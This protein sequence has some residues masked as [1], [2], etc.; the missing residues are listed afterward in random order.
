MN[1]K[2]ILITGSTDGIGKQTALELAKKGHHIIIHGRSMAKCQNAVDDILEEVP[3]AKL[4]SV[5]ADLASLQNIQAMAGTLKQRYE[6]L[7]VLINNAGVFAPKRRISQDGLEINFAVNYLASYFLTCEVLDLIRKSPAGRII[8]VS[9]VAH[10]RGRINFDDLF[11]ENNYQ[12]YK[13]YADSKLMLIYLTYD[14][15]EHLSDEG[16][17]VNALHPGVISTKLLAVGFNMSGDNLSA[18]AETPVYLAVSKEVKNVTG[19]YFD[20]KQAVPSS[21]LSYDKSVREQLMALTKELTSN[22]IKKI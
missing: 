1:K 14:L 20:R 5:P 15:S 17:T 3:D 11:Y 16:I 7:D 6:L 21:P 22:L 19:K 12:A 8:N 18:G 13:A 10:K 9:S 4:D 2:I